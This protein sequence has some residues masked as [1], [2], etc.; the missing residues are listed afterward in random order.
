MNSFFPFTL[1][2]LEFKQFKEL[3][4][5]V[6]GIYLADSKRELLISRFSRRLR[7]LK[8]HSFSE[9]YNFLL[10]PQNSAE[11]EYFINTITTNKTGFF[12]EA[13]HFSFLE[14]SFVQEIK[15]RKEPIRIWSSACS[16]G[17]EPYTTAM[18]LHK[19]LVEPYNIPVSVLATDIDTRVL[20]LA[21]RAV[22]DE[23]S[24]ADIPDDYLHRYFLRSKEKDLGLYKVHSDL[25]DIVS[26]EHFNFIDDS[27]R[28]N[29]GFDVILCRNVIIYFNGPTKA[30][31]IQRL[32][33]M[34]K[35]GGYLIVGHSESLFDIS[36]G[37][38]FIENTIYRR[39]L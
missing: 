21:K 32:K 10:S 8:H 14:S 7:Q 19:H 9:Y 3:V 1:S 23:Q 39:I 15:E 6:A 33:N 36:D 28:F 27:Y 11:I 24:V 22:Y 35:I 25:R 13:H 4:L 30:R 29:P 31:V 17:E 16:T 20:S 2:E 12:R 26:F 38:E 37:L 34:L 5:R 18:V